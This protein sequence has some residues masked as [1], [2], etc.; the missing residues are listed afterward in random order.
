M[1]TPNS[2]VACNSVNTCESDIVGLQRTFE[3]GHYIALSAVNPFC[4]PTIA[5]GV[6]ASA[7]AEILPDIGSPL[8]HRYL[9]VTWVIRRPHRTLQVAANIW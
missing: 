5:D 4:F 8:Q 3:A 6:E 7:L 1:S 9:L 2:I